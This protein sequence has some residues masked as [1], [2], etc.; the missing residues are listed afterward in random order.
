M[1][2]VVTYRLMITPHT[3]INVS[4]NE[5]WMF[6]PEVKDSYLLQIGLKKHQEDIEN[7]KKKIRSPKCYL[8]RKNYIL[9]YYEYKKKV[10]KLFLQSG[11]K[12]YPESNVWFRFFVPM[13]PSWSKKKRD[14]HCFE[15]HQNVPDASNYHKALE[16]SCSEK[17]RRNWDYRASK[18]WIDAPDGYIE[19]EIG[20]LSPA[21]GYRKF[22]LEDKIK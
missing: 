17:D 16:D 6:A 7:K 18:F 22:E 19:I 21:K 10:K 3:K 2:E 14:H 9:R 11:L 1:N 12:E 15:K 5:K 4:E 8:N 13:P 20:S